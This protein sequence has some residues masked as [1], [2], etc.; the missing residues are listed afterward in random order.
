MAS[1]QSADL[2]EHFDGRALL[3]GNVLHAS[4]ELRG[5]IHFEAFS[6]LKT[7]QGCELT[8]HKPADFDNFLLHLDTSAN[9]ANPIQGQAIT[10]LR[11]AFAAQAS[12][13]HMTCLATHGSIALR[14][15]GMLEPWR[16]LG[17]RT[18]MT[19]MRA[20]YQS[21]TEAGSPRFDPLKRQEGRIVN[22]RFLPP[23][24]HS[25]RVHT[26]PLQT[27]NGQ[28]LLMTIRL[29]YDIVKAEGTLSERLRAL[30]YAQEQIQSLSKLSHRPGL[31][32]VAG[33]TGSG[34]TTLLRH[35]FEALACEMPDR[36]FLSIEDPPEYPMQR[37]AQVL[38][39]TSAD[40][41]G[42]AYGAAIAGA[43]RAD[44]DYLMIGEIRHP[45]A[46][47]AAMDAALTGH[48]VWSS[49]HAAS[50]LGIFQRLLSLLFVAKFADPFSNLQDPSVLSGLVYQRLLPK[51]CPYCSLKMAQALQ[52]TAYRG[53]SAFL[54]MLRRLKSQGIQLPAVR[55]RGAGCEHCQGT[56]RSG[57]LVACEI[58]P[59]DQTLLQ[60]LANRDQDEALAYARTLG[61]QTTGQQALQFIGQGH[62]DPRDAE[63][64][65]GF[66][67]EP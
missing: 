33:P 31:T 25:A 66:F 5:N 59:T 27:A 32:L 58:V 28:G 52:D 43:L 51:L 41:R 55:I 49:I 26:E 64:C 56:G 39:D 11:D 47:S 37:I 30:G 6:S 4:T 7:R 15:M 36:S 24:V 44:P 19:L 54:D 53:D 50:A 14:R 21:M 23:T 46:S 18:L 13:I 10:L 57:L 65:L 60:Y 42:A 16:D 20:I 62:L 40:N 1:D 29:L 45:E 9:P 48:P 8:W 17:G 2:S 38:V 22:R 63:N 3:V 34:K 61:L 35:V 12:D 67:P